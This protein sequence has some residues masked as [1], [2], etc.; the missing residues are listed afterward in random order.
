MQSPSR[1]FWAARG[2]AGQEDLGRKIRGG[3]GY[4]WV[5][6]G[7]A[8]R[9]FLGRPSRARGRRIW[10]G[11]SGA[12]R[13]ISGQ[14]QPVRAGYFW[15]V[16]S[17][18]SV[19]RFSVGETPTPGRYTSG[20]RLGRVSYLDK[21]LFSDVYASLPPRSRVC[22]CRFVVGLLREPTSPARGVRFFRLAAEDAHINRMFMRRTTRR[23]S[24]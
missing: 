10:A 13:D 20:K 19:L 21:R 23:W 1:R 24:A 12:G 5:A 9:I 15:A 8:G 11:K 6:R 22:L 14:V 2:G 3:A 17:G 7:G 16:P 18:A 4:F